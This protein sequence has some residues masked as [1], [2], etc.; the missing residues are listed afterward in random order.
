VVE[1]KQA[2]FSA[3]LQLFPPLHGDVREKPEFINSPET[4]NPL[5]GEL[6]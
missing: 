1:K 2:R 6:P 3:N 5:R 4:L